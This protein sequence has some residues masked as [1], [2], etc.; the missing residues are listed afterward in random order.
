M[1]FEEVLIRLIIFSFHMPL[2]FALSCITYKF[3]ST[4][5]ELIRKAK[6]SFRY[7]IFPALAL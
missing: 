3:S 1:V 5:Q 7:L 6:K 4:E 2:F